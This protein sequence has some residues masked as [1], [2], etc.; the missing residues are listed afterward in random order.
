MSTTTDLTVLQ[1]NYLSQAQ[2]DAAVS[3]GTINEN[4]LYMTPS[5]NGEYNSEEWTFVLSA[6][7]EVTKKVVIEQ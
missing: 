7:T 1:I 4:E 2:Y 6:G 5:L 3:G